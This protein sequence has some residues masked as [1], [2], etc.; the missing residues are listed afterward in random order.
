[1]EHEAMNQCGSINGKLFEFEK[2]QNLVLKFP[3]NCPSSAH[4][5]HKIF[6]IILKIYHLTPL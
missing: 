4:T 6:G 3:V 5:Y 1:M 2:F